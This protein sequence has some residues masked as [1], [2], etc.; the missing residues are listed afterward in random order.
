MFLTYTNPVY[1]YKP[2]PDQTSSEPVHHPLIIVGAGPVGMAAAIDAG[3][4]GMKVL[5]LDDNNTVSVG[6]R[7]VCYSKRSLEIMDQL[8]LADRLV[9]KGVT[10][11]VGKTYFRDELVKQFN[12]L[13]SQGYKQPAFINL[14]QY[15]L[16]EYMV[17][18]M[19]ELEGVEVRWKNKVIDVKP[20]ETKV[21]VS[22]ETPDGL[23]QL[24]CDWLIVADGANSPIRSMLGLACVGQVFDDHFLIADILMK[25]DFPPE[26]RFS[27]DPPYHRGWST[28]LHKQPDN[29]WRLDFQ[30]GRDADPEEEK[31]PENVLPRVKAMMGDELEF[32]LEWAS[33]YRFSC[34]Q[35]EKFKHGRLLFI[36]DA[37]HQVSPFG[38][39]GANSGFQDTNNLIWKLKL[40][41]QKKAPESLLN[42]YNEEMVEAAK[43]NLMISRR[44]SD[45]MSPKTPISRL[46]RNAVLELAKNCEFAQQLTDSGRLS[47]PAIHH[48]SSLNTEDSA[49]FDGPLI[50]GVLADDAP[51]EIDGQEEWLLSLLNPRFHLL[52]FIC[53]INDLDSNIVEELK[54][55]KTLA[56]PIEAMI[57]CD[58]AK[59]VD[60]IKVVKDREGWAKTRYDGDPGNCYLI[61]PDQYIAARW[62][63]FDPG[64]IRQAIDRATHRE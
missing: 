55:L 62:K 14:Q 19:N 9:A 11:K 8:G 44:T 29:I 39:R 23:Y 18:R 27:F 42:T 49:H 52:Y 13:P 40:V 5:V 21:L 30:L 15:Y 17:E 26:R 57:I 51:V 1:E 41:M 61:R 2:S 24:S 37:A 35:L 46:F 25:A 58:T 32:E 45:F 6:S 34:R 43:I 47:D 50:P 53:D 33:V 10:W 3:V 36:G 12:L 38:A 54:R 48:Q 56:I 4:Q 16:E 64:K 60:A 7:A 63:N 59:P 28:L 22:I 20:G 31:K